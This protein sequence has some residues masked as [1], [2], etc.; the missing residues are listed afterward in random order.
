MVTKKYFFYVKD[1]KLQK[2]L[3]ELKRQKIFPEVI[4]AVLNNGIEKQLKKR[5]KDIDKLLKNVKI[6]E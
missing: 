3:D 5:A 4:Q 6:K 2:I 1:E